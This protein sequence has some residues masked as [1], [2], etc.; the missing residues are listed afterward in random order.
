VDGT[1][2]GKH[3][4]DFAGGLA[5]D[6][7][8]MRNGGFFSENVPANQKSIRRAASGKKAKVDFQVLETDQ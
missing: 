6:G 3:R 7:F 8:F 1:G 4:L 2:G 5:G